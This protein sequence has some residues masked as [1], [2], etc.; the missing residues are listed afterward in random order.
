MGNRAKEANAMSDLSY[1]Y[2]CLKQPTKAI[3]YSQQALAIACET[4]DRE[5][6]AS[7]LASLAN[8]YWHQQQYVR[9]LWLVMQSLLI[10]PPWAS[11]NGELIFRQTVKEIAQLAKILIHRW[12]CRSFPA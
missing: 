8:I 6:K 3:E 11:P 9:A 1:C 7:V 4:G 10:L 2:S 12:F 5:A